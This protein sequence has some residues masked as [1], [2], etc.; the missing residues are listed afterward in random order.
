MRRA[1]DTYMVYQFI[2]RL[3]RPFNAWDAYKSGVIDERG[4]ILIKKHERTSEQRKSFTAFDLMILKLKNLL[5]KAPGGSSKI[6]SYIAALWLIKEWN[7]FTDNT[8]L[9]ENTSETTINQSLSLFLEWYLYYLPVVEEVNRKIT[10]DGEGAPTVNV[11]SG[12]IAGLGVGPQGE[13][14]L[15]KLQQTRH[16]KRAA[17][18]AVDTARRKAFAAF[19]GEASPEEAGYFAQEDGYQPDRTNIER[20]RRL[21]K[22]PIPTRRD[23]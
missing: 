18:T 23:T 17:A 20:K 9:N 7:H 14:G 12:N 22:H 11:G 6:A 2:R 13:P 21:K 19:I 15:T 3:S 4:N 8:T 1:I 5:G 16:K 10:E